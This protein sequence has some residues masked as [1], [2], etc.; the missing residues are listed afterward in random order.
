MHKAIVTQT[1][2][3]KPDIYMGMMGNPFK[4]RYNL[5]NSSFRLLNDVKKR[6]RAL[7]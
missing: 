6:Q 5:H 1:E 2:L 7:H 4:I 3:I